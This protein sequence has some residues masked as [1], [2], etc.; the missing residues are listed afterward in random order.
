MSMINSKDLTYKPP[1]TFGK[2][3]QGTYANGFNHIKTQ[4]Q[5][6]WPIKDVKKKVDNK[7]YEPVKQGGV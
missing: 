6:R 2:L 5:Y 1:K 3:W 7:N 4:E